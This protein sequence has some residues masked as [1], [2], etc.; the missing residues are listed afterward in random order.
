MV[1]GLVV[2]VILLSGLLVREARRH[3]RTARIDP[4]TGLANR[5]ALL[6]KMD[7]YVTRDTSFGLVLVDINDF[8]DIN[9]KFGYNTGDLLLQEV[10][11]RLRA[12]CENGEWVA[13]LGGDQLAMLQREERSSSGQGARG[14]SAPLHQARHHHR[15]LP[16]PA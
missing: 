5:L 4:L 7:A 14:Q 11:K 1:S 6:E 3:F 16:F 2:S 12:L 9:S 15:Q 8:R 10:A 13:R